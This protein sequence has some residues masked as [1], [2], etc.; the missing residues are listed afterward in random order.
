[1][2]CDQVFDECDHDEQPIQW[3][4]GFQRSA[5]LSIIKPA[6]QHCTRHLSRGPP[7][8]IKH[9][10]RDGSFQVDGFDQLPSVR[11]LP[12]IA[13]SWRHGRLGDATAGTSGLNIGDVIAG[14]LA[15]TVE[16]ASI[17]DERG[18]PAEFVVCRPTPSGCGL[19]ERLTVSAIK[20]NY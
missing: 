8:E 1:M 20:T 6:I 17:S 4:T 11:Y 3:V 15:C 7:T 12:V 18:E 9:Q 13:L 19:R 5:V 16:W 10:G 2:A 14:E